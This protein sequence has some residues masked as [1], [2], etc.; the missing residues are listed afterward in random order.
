MDP[1][2]FFKNPTCHTSS[3]FSN[4]WDSLPSYDPET[5]RAETLET[6][7]I[8]LSRGNT[9]TSSVVFSD[10]ESP[11][12][13]VNESLNEYCSSFDQTRVLKRRLVIA[14]ADNSSASNHHL[15]RRKELEKGP[16]ITKETN[17]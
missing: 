4:R 15:A 13:K 7:N 1:H 5:N 11:A 9:R 6:N 12:D 17:D 14:K 16:W 8:E 10:D 2:C 3:P